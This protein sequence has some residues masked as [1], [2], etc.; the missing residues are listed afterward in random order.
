MLYTGSVMNNKLN[1]P[2][3][4]KP[5]KNYSFWADMKV[6]GWV[7]VAALIWGASACL[8]PHVV[9]Q[10]P[11]AWQ[12][13]IVLAQVGA[14]LLWVRDLARWI[15]GR[16]ELHQRITLAAILFAVSATF[17]FVMLWHRLDKVGFFPASKNPN[18]SWDITTVG[19]RILL[20]ALFY[21]L[22]H[23]IFNRRYK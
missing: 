11:I 14:I 22:G 13:I 2:D 6:N 23:T 19:H 12:V 20:L 4:V 21:F 17:F 8:F 15:R 10:W 1:V 7:C 5:G 16:D 18:A 9:K 3:E